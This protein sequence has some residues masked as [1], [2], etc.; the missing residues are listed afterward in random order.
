MM[1]KVLFE[2]KKD[3]YTGD[4]EFSILGRDLVYYSFKTFKCCDY[5]WE[6]KYIM[7]IWVWFRVSKIVGWIVKEIEKKCV[8]NMVIWLFLVFLIKMKII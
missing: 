1:V 8:K 4:E 6:E 5:W 7:E 3:D 2:R